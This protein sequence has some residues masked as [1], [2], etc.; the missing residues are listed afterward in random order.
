MVVDLISDRIEEARR[1][2]APGF[3]F[4][5]DLLATDVAIYVD[6]KDFALNLHGVHL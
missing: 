2:S 6:D 5:G 3:F 4:G 1:Q